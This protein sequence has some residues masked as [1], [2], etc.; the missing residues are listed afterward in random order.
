MITVKRL[1]H[2]DKITLRDEHGVLLAERI[3]TAGRFVWRCFDSIAQQVCDEWAGGSTSEAL[4]EMIDKF[5]C[6]RADVR[7]E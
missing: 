7:R 1:L 2:Q 6:N 5:R 4:A 3:R